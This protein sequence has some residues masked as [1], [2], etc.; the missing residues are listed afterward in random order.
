[1]INVNNGY[2][3]KED[4][5]ASISQYEADNRHP[6]IENILDSFKQRI[7]NA[8]DFSVSIKR[9]NLACKGVRNKFYIVTT[10]VLI[11]FFFLQVLH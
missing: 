4:V 6:D 8:I 9:T 1:M 11:S 7:E 10:E 3:I 2:L 5:L